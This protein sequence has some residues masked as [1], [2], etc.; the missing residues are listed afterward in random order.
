MCFLIT[1]NATKTVVTHQL[2]KSVT[3]QIVLLLLKLLPLMF[4]AL[5]LF[6]GPAVAVVYACSVIVVNFLY[7]LL[8]LSFA[9]HFCN[10]LCLYSLILMLLHLLLCYT[11][12]SPRCS[13]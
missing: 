6:F 2:N 10:Y 5:M 8:L 7:L 12:K 13:S 4:Q 9:N 1:F 11:L 3:E